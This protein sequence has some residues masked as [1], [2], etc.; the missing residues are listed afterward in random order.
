MIREN[1][2]NDG[3]LDFLIQKFDNSM[4]FVQSLNNPIQLQSY[5]YFLRLALNNLQ[6][7]DFDYLL[8]RLNNNKELE[9]NDG[10]YSIEFLG[11]NNPKVAL[12]EVI[13]Y[14]RDNLVKTRVL[15]DQFSKSFNSILVAD[16]NDCEFLKSN[17]KAPNNSIVTVTDAFGSI[18]SNIKVNK[19][20]IL[21]L[22]E[23]KAKM[24]NSNIVSE[25]LLFY[26]FNGEKDFNFLYNLPNYVNLVLYK[27]EA[28]SYKKQLQNY[29]HKLEEELIRKERFNLC[30]IKYESVKDEIIQENPTLK[31][32]IRRLD[33]RSQTAYNIYINESDL[34]LDE[35]GYKTQYEILF[36]NGCTVVLD[37]NDIVFDFKGNLKK[38][39]DLRKNENIRIYPKEQLAEN[40]LQIAIE[41][42]PEIFG[43]VETHA[44]LW[45]DTLKFLDKIYPTREQLYK[46]LNNLG[47]KVLP[48]TVDSYFKGF[49]KYPMYNGDLK[50]II[51]LSNNQELTSQIPHILKS[52]RL[53]ISTM[54]ALGRGIKQELRQFLKENIIGELLIKRGFTKATLQKFTEEQMPLV[55]IKDIQTVKY[56]QEQ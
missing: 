44:K 47:L 41:S 7:E 48:Q 38:T 9:H 29:K 45:L 52:K 20:S 5:G 37:S 51:L 31:S 1:I 36:N 22:N 34:L 56:E 43:K 33:E 10:G 54:I 26:K 49:R 24:R 16:Q 55:I 27:Q 3:Y 42:E 25:K 21:T 8:I 2:I 14:M 12:Y 4:A 17:I 35:L 46:E 39:R 53:Y 30:G 13:R 11:D 40:L 23:L 18:K 6:Q 19:N 50:A 32:I 28:A 15:I